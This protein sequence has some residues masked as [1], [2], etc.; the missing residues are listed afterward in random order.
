MKKKKQCIHD[1]L[2]TVPWHDAMTHRTVLSFHF[3]IHISAADAT[4]IVM[5]VN[6]CFIHG[7]PHVQALCHVLAIGHVR[8]AQGQF[9]RQ[10]RDSAYQANMRYLEAP[11]FFDS[12]FR[13]AGTPVIARHL[14]STSNENAL[15]NLTE[16]Q[17][18]FTKCSKFPIFPYLCFYA[19]CSF[20]IVL[21]KFFCNF[22]VQ[23]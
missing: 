14:F 10:T 23:M 7:L 3:P 8:K 20:C 11:E 2:S 6:T 13:R 19:N 1:Q 21:K 9:M 12:K 18:L 22:S 16:R 17:I 5:A 15:Y 4:G